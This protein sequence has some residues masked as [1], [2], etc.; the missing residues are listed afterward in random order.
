MLLEKPNLDLLSLSVYT[1]ITKLS[2][3]LKVKEKVI[4]QL[5]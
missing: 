3:S 1:P 2:F 5:I 4:L